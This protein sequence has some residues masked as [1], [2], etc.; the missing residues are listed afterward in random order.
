M[1]CTYQD[2]FATAQNSFWTHQFWCFLVLLLLFVSPLP[3]LQNVFLWGL[4]PSK[5]TNKQTKTLGASSCGGEGPCS[6]LSKC[7][8]VRCAHKSPI[9]KW[10]NPLKESS[11]NSLNLNAA[12]H[13]T[14][15][16]YTETDRFL[17]HSPN[18]GSLYYK[19]PAFWEIISGFF[20]PLCT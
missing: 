16:W 14:T 8:V 4:F 12:S 6:F 9:M 19:G 3:H 20:D 5:E 13:N 11:K 18:R 15:S 10:A 2:I 1:Q 7:G 17:L